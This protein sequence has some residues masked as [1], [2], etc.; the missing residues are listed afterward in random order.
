M[1]H[2]GL[3]TDFELQ[4]TIYLSK[5]NSEGFWNLRGNFKTPSFIQHAMGGTNHLN[6][7]HEYP[8]RNVSFGLTDYYKTSFFRGGT[9]ITYTTT[10]DKKAR[11]NA[12]NSNNTGVNLFFSLLL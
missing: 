3:S 5:L 8:Y 11:L 2:L 7:L 10:G 4:N 1:K 6:L 12:F 9:D